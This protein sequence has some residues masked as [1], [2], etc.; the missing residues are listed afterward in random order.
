MNPPNNS[1]S[2]GQYCFQFG[3]PLAV[4]LGRPQE[5][6]I[7]TIVKDMIHYL[8]LCCM[9]LSFF[10]FLHLLLAEVTNLFL[11][12]PCN[13]ILGAAYSRVNQCF[14]KP[15][16]QFLI[17]F[18][19]ILKIRIRANGS[20]YCSSSLYPIFSRNPWWSNPKFLHPPSTRSRLWFKISL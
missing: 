1:I 11:V 9:P 8:C 7:P 17:S 2:T 12:K 20:T 6:V 18:C 15:N 5:S 3:V 13:R 14:Q 10:P 4:V 19:S 16:N